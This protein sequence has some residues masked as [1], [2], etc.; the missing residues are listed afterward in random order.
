MFILSQVQPASQPAPAH[1]TPIKS[2]RSRRVLPPS[3]TIE[4]INLDA[5]PQC[6]PRLDNTAAKHKL[7]VKPKNQ[8]ISRKHRRFTHVRAC[9]EHLH[10]L[11]ELTTC[12]F[13]VG[14]LP[15][16]FEWAEPLD[17]IVQMS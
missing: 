11:G 1:S 7:S 10:N 4:S 6:A 9:S 17:K 2:P 5:V 13:P 16:P 8:R 3:G 15:Q 12:H 14:N